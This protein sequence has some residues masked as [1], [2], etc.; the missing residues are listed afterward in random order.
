[1]TRAPQL[2]CVAAGCQEGAIAVVYTPVFRAPYCAPCF[3]RW[4][5]RAGHL[6]YETRPLVDEI[7]RIV[8]ECIDAVFPELPS[9]GPQAAYQGA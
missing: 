1:M 2:V 9:P 7:V 5:A 4:E 6:P 8:R 3:A